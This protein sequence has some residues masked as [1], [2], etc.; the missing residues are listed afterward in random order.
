LISGI[1]PAENHVYD[2]KKQMIYAA[3]AINPAFYRRKSAI[4]TRALQGLSPFCQ[5]WIDSAFFL[6]SD[7]A[8]AST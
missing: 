2:A 4:P 1:L 8:K 3:T 7:Q 6:P 5:G